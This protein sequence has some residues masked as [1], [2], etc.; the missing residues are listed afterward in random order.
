MGEVRM[1]ADE[2][3]AKLKDAW[4]AGYE[5]GMK[6]QRDLAQQGV[7]ARARQRAIELAA[8]LKDAWQAGYKSGLKRAKDHGG[9]GQKRLAPADDQ[10]WPARVRQRR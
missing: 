7:V 10:E 5:S 4:N 1:S 6:R 9:V 2:L 3:A 8:K